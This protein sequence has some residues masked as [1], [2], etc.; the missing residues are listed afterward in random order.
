[1]LPRSTADDI[2][3]S[4]PPD[5]ISS[6]KVL[7]GN[8]PVAINATN[9]SDFILSKPGKRMGLAARGSA[10]LRSVRHVF[11]SR[12][13]KEMFWVAA[14]SIISRW[15]VVADVNIVHDQAVREHPCYAVSRGVESAAPNI[16][17]SS[18]CYSPG[19]K[20]TIIRS[21]DNHSSPKPLLEWFGQINSF[22]R[23]ATARIRN[24]LQVSRIYLKTLFA[25][26]TLDFDGHK[27][28]ILSCVSLRG[29]SC[30][31]E[32]S[33]GWFLLFYYS[34]FQPQGN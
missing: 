7:K 28:L 18:F 4:L 25:D 21:F 34:W 10:L 13:F 1:M 19:P 26:R 11:A 30:E 27:K 31:S 6:S 32:G 17:V 29:C 24:L 20:P 9:L 23:V 12:S 8:A 22:A 14:K 5:A 33:P 15:A 2:S 16:P 3:D